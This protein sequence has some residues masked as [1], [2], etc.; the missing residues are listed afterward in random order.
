MDEEEQGEEGWQEGWEEDADEE[1][2]NQAEA[3]SVSKDEDVQEGE[4]DVE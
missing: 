1:L 3:D 2:A 4:E